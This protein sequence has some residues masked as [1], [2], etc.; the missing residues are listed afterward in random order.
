MCIRDSPRLLEG[1]LLLV[2]KSAAAP[3]G[4]TVVLEQQQKLLV[5]NVSC[6]L[7]TS[8]CV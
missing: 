7:Y 3:E 2:K 4:A 6:L 1:D 8:R 5:R